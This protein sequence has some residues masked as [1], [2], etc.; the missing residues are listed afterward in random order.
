MSPIRRIISFFTNWLT[1]LKQKML[2]AFGKKIA[3][4]LNPN[5]LF[6]F[7]YTKP[8]GYSGDFFIIEKIYQYYLSQDVLMVGTNFCIQPVQLL[9]CGEQ[10]NSG[11]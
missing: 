3:S 4:I 2:T 7:S 5:S 9:Q 6:G 10:E 11:Y 1:R 8:F